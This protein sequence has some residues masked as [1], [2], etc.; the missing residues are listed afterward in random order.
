MDVRRVAV[1]GAALVGVVVA[2][3]AL[4]YVLFHVFERQQDALERPQSSVQALPPRQT[5]P[6]IPKLQG[7]AGFHGNTP[8][9]DMY[10]LRNREA[11]VLNS[12][13][14]GIEPGTARIPIA[15]A[16]DLIVD[17]KL[18]K[19][20]PRAANTT[21]PAKASATGGTHGP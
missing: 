12:Y 5:D 19:S 1:A 3:F 21:Q 13:G 7:V 20:Q 16:M 2:T 15:R 10:E 8:A 6:D 4:L 18:L 11:Q 9:Q 14:P 17:Q